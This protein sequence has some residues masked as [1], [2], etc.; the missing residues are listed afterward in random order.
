MLSN[1]SKG[2]PD[3]SQDSSHSA[4]SS[5]SF[6][7]TQTHHTNP[8]ITHSSIPTH[9]HLRSSDAPRSREVMQQW[10]T[11]ASEDEEL[12]LALA[13]SASLHGTSPPPAAQAAGRQQ[14][15]QQ[16]PSRA[17]MP[18]APP[19]RAPAGLPSYPQQPARTTAPSR[20]SPPPPQ[21]QQR[22]W[23]GGGPDVCPGCGVSVTWS[24]QHV[25][26]LGH[27]WHLSC[28]RCGLCKEPL[29]GAHGMRFVQGKDGQAYHMAC[30]KTRFHPVCVVCSECFV[31]VDENRTSP[32]VT[33]A[34]HVASSMWS[35]NCTWSVIMVRWDSRGCSP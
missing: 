2:L 10:S 34:L 25:Q 20:P 22:P 19:Q 3:S 11:G 9:P 4:D 28:L 33:W 7:S 30:H 6:C 23:P 13:L 29:H 1:D 12:Q 8:H 16:P 32:S 26:A 5:E 18:T 31:P 24:G 14:P 21:Q 15:S 27:K 35:V 17:A